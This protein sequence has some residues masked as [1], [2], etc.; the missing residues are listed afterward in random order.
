MRHCSIPCSISA[1]ES[2]GIG[3]GLA[4][5]MCAPDDAA[6]R[7]S[8]QFLVSVVADRA[9]RFHCAHRRVWPGNA[10]VAEA[11]FFF[12][13]SPMTQARATAPPPPLQK[14]RSPV[15]RRSNTVPG[16][17]PLSGRRHCPFQPATREPQRNGSGV[18]QDCQPPGT[19]HFRLKVLRRK[20]RIFHQN[21]T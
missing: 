21:K 14:G 12:R 10:P 6:T 2:Q 19:P 11:A 18:Q 8:G 15:L 1:I 5:K 13:H 7:R 17:A 20:T 3:V 9:C 16:K 4:G